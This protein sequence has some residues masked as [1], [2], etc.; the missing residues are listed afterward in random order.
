[1][2]RVAGAITA[3]L[4]FPVLVGGAAS[5]GGVAPAAQTKALRDIPAEYA[6]LYL[7]AAAKYG[8]PWQLLAAVGK[9]ECDH[10]RGDCYRPNEAGAMGPMQFMPGTWP[11]YRTSSGAPPYSV[12]DAR[13]AVFAAAAK[14]EADNVATSPEGALYAYNHSDS[15]VDEVFGWALSYGWVPVEPQLLARAVLESP[16]IDLRPDARSDVLRGLVDVRVLAGLLYASQGHHLG[17]VGPFVTGHSVYVAG[18]TRVSNHAVGRAVDIPLVDGQP[19]SPSNAAAREVAERL[20]MLP[21]L[22][23]PDELG[24]PWELPADGTVVFTENHDD[25]LHLG[26]SS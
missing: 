7:D 14:L 25:H 8:I 19:V 17:Y 6:Q 18:T 16:N 15:Y 20:L 26:Y 4:L 12:Y 1:M 13:D 22:L 9:V 21:G 11:A 3:L 24:A 2:K 5:G 10:G 23:E